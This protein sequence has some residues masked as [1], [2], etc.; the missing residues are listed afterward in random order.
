MKYVDYFL[1]PLLKLT[2][3]L[4]LPVDTSCDYEEK[5]Y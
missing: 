3:A 4:L 1:V 2:L 5:V